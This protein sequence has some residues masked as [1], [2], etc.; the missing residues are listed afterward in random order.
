M[1]EFRLPAEF[2]REPQ[3]QTSTRRP[4]GAR[5]VRTFRIYRFDPTSGE[6]PRVDTF[7]LESRAAGRWFSMR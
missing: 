6:N 2:P 5:E 3:R 1:A 7:E 4:P